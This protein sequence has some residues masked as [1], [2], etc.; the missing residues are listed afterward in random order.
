MLEHP[1]HIVEIF[2]APTTFL[3]AHST[4]HIL[5][6]Y[7][8]QYLLSSFD[9]FLGVV[10]IDMVGLNNVWL[11]IEDIMAKHLDSPLNVFF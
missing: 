7:V 1:L 10:E 6:V 5:L 8:C 11:K 3:D 4:I 2:L 9:L